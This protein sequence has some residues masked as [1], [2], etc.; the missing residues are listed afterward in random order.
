MST[1]GRIAIKR[2][3]GSYISCYHNSD[4]YPEYLGKLLVAHWT[5]NE[6]IEEAI[7]LG[8]SSYWAE[9]IEENRYYGRDYDESDID[10]LVSQNIQTLIEDSKIAWEEYLYVRE[11]GQWIA[12]KNGKKINLLESVKQENM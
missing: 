7:N 4:S 6:K 3:D 8:D 10:P 2:K 12:F 9:T 11:R 5:N 1:Q